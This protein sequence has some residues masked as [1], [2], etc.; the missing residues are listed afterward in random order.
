MVKWVRNMIHGMEDNC[1]QNFVRKNVNNIHEP[2]TR[3]SYPLLDFTDTDRASLRLLQSMWLQ[4]C[5]IW[6]A[7]VLCHIYSVCKLLHLCVVCSGIH[8]SST[9]KVTFAWG[10]DVF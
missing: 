10:A 6:G 4:G 3:V 5:T 7:P 2:K 1:T 9:C 8:V